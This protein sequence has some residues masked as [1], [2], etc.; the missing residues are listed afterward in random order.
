MRNMRLVE[1]KNLKLGTKLYIVMGLLSATA[2]LI[3]GTGYFAMGRINDL[4]SYQCDLNMPELLKLGDVRQGLMN[5]IRHEK[6]AIIS[7]DDKE[8]QGYADLATKSIEEAES[9]FQKVQA[10]YAKD[11][12]ASDAERKGLAEL[13][14]MIQKMKA[15]DKSLLELAVQNTGVKAAELSTTKANESIEAV[16]QAI[17]AL[18]EQWLKD[19]DAEG[20]DL[21]ARIAKLGLASEIIGGAGHAYRIEVRHINSTDEAGMAKIR[22]EGNKVHEQVKATI[23]RLDA[24]ADE[25]EKPVVASAASAWDAFVAVSNQV[26]DLSESNTNT[27]SANMSLKEQKELITTVVATAD[28]MLDAVGK[29][30]DDLATKS[31]RTYAVMLWVLLG[32]G[33]AGILLSVSIAMV[34]IRSATKS[35]RGV[36]DSLSVGSEQVA[37]ASSQVAQSSQSMAEGASE[38]ASSLEETSASLEEMSSMT[39]QNAENAGE[40]KGMANEARA[41]ATKGREAMERMSEAINRIKSS[42]DQTAKILKTIDEIAFQTNLLALNAAVEAARAGEAG[43]GFAVVA[44]EVRNLAQRSAEAAKNTATLIEEAQKNADSGVSVSSE[45]H[46]IF[47]GIGATADKVAQLVAEVAAASHEQAQGIEQVN[48]AVSQMD[49]VTQSNAANSEEAA[50]AA[51]ELSAQADQ[52]REIIESLVR[53]VGRSQNETRAS[54]APAAVSRR[55]E[56]AIHTMKAQTNGNGHHNGNGHANGNGNGHGKAHRNGN[57]K[58]NGRTV[59]PEEVIPL[60]ADEELAEF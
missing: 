7:T 31:K 50:S 36:V 41:V 17:A 5:T 13:S 26:Y 20:V 59:K 44:E 14:D 1:V 43:K 3:G 9:N 4:L 16:F 56:I 23:Q 28:R 30:S 6:N 11:T 60:E 52:M 55:P 12:G 47:M 21:K 35:L 40:A 34:I 15:A 10:L 37:S 32:M 39:N 54:H 38:Q 22:E 46:E 19:T 49:H 27:K 58:A 8:A 29:T 57:G 53:I 24:M 2:M 51:E 45:V 25:G 42:S 33:I 48:T 18:R